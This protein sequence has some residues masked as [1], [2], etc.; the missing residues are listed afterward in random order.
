MELDAGKHIARHAC[1]PQ[2]T[3]I[4]RTSIVAA[5]GA[6][7]C[8]SLVERLRDDQLEVKVN[9][10][11]ALIS[12]LVVPQQVFGC[13]KAGILPILAEMV[14]DP[15]LVIR[16]RAAQCLALIAADAGGRVAI[17]EVRCRPLRARTSTCSF[18]LFHFC[19]GTFP[20]RRSKTS[21]L[22]CDP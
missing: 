7:M 5:Y 3:V 21:S 2:P 17:A 11:R 8:P 9:T 20:H 15:E 18:D 14:R 12:E 4:A 10:F 13:I 6:R 22:R 16:Q 1:M 19:V